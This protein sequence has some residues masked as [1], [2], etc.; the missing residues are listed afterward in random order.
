MDPLWLLIALV[1]GLVAGMPVYLAFRRSSAAPSFEEGSWADLNIQVSLA[2][3]DQRRPRRRQIARISRPGYPVPG[4]TSA[5]VA[6]SA[7]SP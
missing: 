6:A 2:Q 3:L 4:M 5:G 1:F 7:G